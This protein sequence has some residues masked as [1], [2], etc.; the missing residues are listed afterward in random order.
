MSR[1]RRRAVLLA[2]QR[3]AADR[4]VLEV[5]RGREVALLWSPRWRVG[6][7][8][9]G[10]ASRRQHRLNVPGPEL[11]LEEDSVGQHRVHG[12]FEVGEAG[13]L[14]F[15]LQLVVRGPPARCGVR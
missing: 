8:D 3:N 4:T 12:G 5:W 13:E 6:D 9:R 10:G 7:A 11:R 2:E 15:V 1:L 14:G